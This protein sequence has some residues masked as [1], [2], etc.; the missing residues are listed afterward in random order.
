[1][2]LHE[3]RPRLP[4]AV[5]KQQCHRKRI[6]TER[7]ELEIPAGVAFAASSFVLV[8]PFDALL[9]NFKSFMIRHPDLIQPIAIFAPL[10]SNVRILVVL[11]GLAI[12]AVC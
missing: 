3:I 9:Q 2:N 10:Q 8:L 4:M 12:Q 1:M 7:N 5:A 6:A 11:K